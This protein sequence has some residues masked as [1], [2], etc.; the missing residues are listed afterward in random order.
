M[1]CN[2]ESE[3]SHFPESYSIQI[4]ENRIYNFSL[5]VFSLQSISYNCNSLLKI[6]SKSVSPSSKINSK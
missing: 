2:P 5:Y 6:L 1:F 4:Y 3:S